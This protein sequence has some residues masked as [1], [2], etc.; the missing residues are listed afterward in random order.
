MVTKR[1]LD[2]LNDD[3]SANFQAILTQSIEELKNTIIDNLKKSNELLQIKV[4]SLEN[5]IDLLKESNVEYVKHTEASLQHGRLE[6]IILSGIPESVQQVE[7]EDKSRAILNFYKVNPVE[8]R[9][10]AACHRVGK[11]PDVI[12]RFVNRK[13][14]EDCLANRKKLKNLDLE[15]LG[16][17]P[18]TKIFVN[19][20]LSP[21][22]SKI[23]YY[24]RTL[25]RQNLIEKVTTFK[26]VVKIF[27]LIDGS[28]GRNRTVTNVIGH[29]QDLQKIFPNLDE[30]L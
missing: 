20:N 10:I 15:A 25:K 3:L 5:E 6:N 29:K 27:R 2:K 7:L 21:Y 23:A 19:E 28:P 22:M 12:L 16:F 1:D 9:D 13:D 8:C 11:K 24:C 30:F 17:E 14:A 18:G 26:G 4:K